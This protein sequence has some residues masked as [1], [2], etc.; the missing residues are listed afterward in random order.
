MKL[1]RGCGTRVKGGIYL[2]TEM[3]ENGLPVEAFLC[4]PP[5]VVDMK[6]LGISAVGHTIIQ[7]QK[8]GTLIFDWVGSGFYPNVADFVEEVRRFGVSR[9]ISSGVDFSSITGTATIVFLHQK[10]YIDDYPLY[11]KNRVGIHVGESTN[12]CCPKSKHTI[13]QEIMCAGLWWEDVTPASG[14]LVDRNQRKP[15]MRTMPS[16]SYEAAPPATGSITHT[17]AIFAKFPVHRIAVVYDDQEGKHAEAYKKASRAGV[18]VHVV[19]E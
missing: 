3:S 12:S 8:I 6:K 13:D 7:D 16:F 4:D 18:P 17:P 11:V 1:V 9:R 10:A 2:E 5:I 14:E 15:Y 19:E